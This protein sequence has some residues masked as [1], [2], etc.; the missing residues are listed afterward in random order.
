V[1][2]TWGALAWQGLAAIVTLGIF[3]F[4]AGDNPFYKIIE[5]TWVGVTT[6]YWLMLL[7]HTSFHDKVWVN[8]VV[9]HKWWYILPTFLGLLMWLR[10]SRK[11]A[12]ISRY[13]LA[14]YIGISTG[15]YIPLAFKNFV[16]LQLE[17]A[18]RPISFDAAG[19]NFV[20]ALVGLTCSLSY[21]FFS[22]PH[23]G[24]LGGMS[25]AGILTL[26]IGFGAG[27]GLTVM[28]RVAL[29]VQRVIFLR[30]YSVNLFGKIF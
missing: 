23:T 4:L 24:I 13:A 27:F 14:F 8:I 15:I 26:M 21:F 11:L 1:E 20:I 2:P 5:R 16:F 22:K 17:G 7:Y 19:I 18:V 30:D 10:L 6:G 9:Q 12:W 3:S 29:L 28:G 25:K